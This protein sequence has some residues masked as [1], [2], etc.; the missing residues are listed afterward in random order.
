MMFWKKDRLEVEE[1]RRQAEN[2]TRAREAARLNLQ[3]SL[4]RLARR[5]EEIP[6]DAGLASIGEDLAGNP[7]RK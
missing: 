6:L 3:R 4:K 5:L 7:E 2:D 1:L